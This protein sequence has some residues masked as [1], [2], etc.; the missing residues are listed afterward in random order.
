MIELRFGP[1]GK[2]PAAQ[3]STV[4]ESLSAIAG[5]LQSELE[6]P[7]KAREFEH[8]IREVIAGRQESSWGA[9][10]GYY[11]NVRKTVSEVGL[12]IGEPPKTIS[13]PTKDL[14]EA[15][16]EW[17]DYLEK[18]KTWPEWALKGPGAK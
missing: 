7:Y 18:S 5:F 8:E 10:N 13:V 16:E 17:A 3:V 4:D 12:D 11:F 9:G 14:L 2:F 15:V 6:T 1:T